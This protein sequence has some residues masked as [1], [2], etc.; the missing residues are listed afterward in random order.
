M[1]QDNAVGSGGR[2]AKTV[3]SNVTNAIM[4]GASEEGNVR[5]SIN[6]LH[7][8]EKYFKLLSLF[9]GLKRR[10]RKETRLLISQRK[11]LSTLLEEYIKVKDIIVVN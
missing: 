7:L 9:K 3:A 11:D 1:V 10:N 4:V 2:K 6:Q 5:N 8:L